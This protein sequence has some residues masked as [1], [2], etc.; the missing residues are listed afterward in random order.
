MGLWAKSLRIFNSFCDNAKQ[1]IRQVA[2]Q[3]L[4]EKSGHERFQLM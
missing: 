1:S 4:F 2:S 3:R